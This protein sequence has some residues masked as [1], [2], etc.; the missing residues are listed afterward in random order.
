MPY[1]LSPAAEADLEAIWAYTVDLWSS[2]QA[3]RYFETLVA[4]FEALAINPRIGQR[5]DWLREGYR[6]FHAGHHLIFY[7]ELGEGEV[8]VIRV[9]HEKSDVA[10]RLG[11]V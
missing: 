11:K 4:A 9:L 3:E 2:Q 10:S 7:T 5:V 8:D 6:R 1:R